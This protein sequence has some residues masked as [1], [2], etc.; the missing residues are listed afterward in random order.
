MKFSDL[1]QGNLV[2]A[3][4]ASAVDRIAAGVHR[5]AQ[6]KL[7]AKVK[8]MSENGYELTPGLKQAMRMPLIH[9]QLSHRFPWGIIFID[10][11]GRRKRLRYQFLSQAIL[12]H[13]RFHLA[14]PEAH[15]A[16]VVSLIRGYNVP[17]KYRGRL[18]KP[19]K[20]CPYCMKPRKYKP[21]LD[22]DGNKQVFFANVKTWNNTKKIYEYRDRKLL[23]MECPLCRHTNRDHVF[24]R[25]NQPWELIRIPARRRSYRRRAR[26]VTR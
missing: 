16:T 2:K 12:F 15:D 3:E 22:R 10:E 23:L 19:W 18:P 4:Y 13:S 1:Y 26:K 7:S 6:A 9:S 8:E 21:A 11:N 5:R 17:A 14:F 24:R 20:W 25:A